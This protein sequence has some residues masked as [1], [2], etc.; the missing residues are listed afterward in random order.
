MQVPVLAFRDARAVTLFGHVPPPLPAGRSPSR[1]A[2][3]RAYASVRRDGRAAR[4]GLGG[5]AQD[6]G[7]PAGLRPERHAILRPPQVALQPGG[8][9][10]PPRSPRL[11]VP[12]LRP[13]DPSPHAL[14][15]P[16]A[17]V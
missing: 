1:V 2:R 6:R 15:L 14:P 8:G 5:R 7:D 10:D 3:Y 13:R 17:R 16:R 12:T 4:A 9:M 11:L